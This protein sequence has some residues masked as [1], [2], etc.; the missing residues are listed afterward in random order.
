MNLLY[1]NDREGVYPQSWY[2]A[3]ATMLP[4]F[5]PLDGD[6]KHDVCVIGGGYSGLSCALHLAEN[7][8][9][10]VLLDAHR[11][12][13]GASG[14]NGG[15]LGSGQRLRQTILEKKYGADHARK[16]WQLG[17]EAKALVRS[18][19]E[20]FAISC[21]YKPGIVHA[22]HRARFV[23]N[24][25]REVDLLREAYGYQKIRFVERAELRQMLATD[26]YHGGSLDTGSGHLHPLNFALGLARAAAQAGVRILERTQVTAVR[27]G[28]PARVETATGNVRAN[29]VLLACNGYLGLLES[30]VARRV[31]PINNYILATRP[32]PQ[33]VARQLIRDDVA[34]AD[35]RFVIN[36]FRLSVDCRLIFG[37]GESYGYRFPAD[38]K[39]YVRKPMIEIYPQLRDVQIDY[40]WGGTLAITMSRLP[41][42][43]RLAPNILSIS[44]Y[45]GHGL[46]MATLSGKLAAQAIRGTAERFDVLAS[47]PASAFPGGPAMRWPLLVLAMFYHA[48]LDR[49]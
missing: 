33:D 3:S 27:K 15:Q 25:K 32:L 26:A 28:D 19:I 12:G 34:V 42:L 1:S 46:G 13:W 9:D 17:E 49:V 45:S 6:R 21:D 43:A 36:Y 31:M 20:R 4:E 5:P 29:F 24:T 23:G 47:L 41:H 8:Y 10:V 22:D 44:G 37:G 35:S 48:M 18:L 39:A 11:V 2:A 40:G 38:I 30:D 16:L 7:G 14:R